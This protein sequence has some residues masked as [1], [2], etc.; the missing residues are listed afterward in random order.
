MFVS[1][2]TIYYED[3]SVQGIKP[4]EMFDYSQANVKLLVNQIAGNH[5]YSHYV[6][7]VKERR[8]NRW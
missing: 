1:M 8:G 4:S 2:I 7:G 3:G 5:P 6:D